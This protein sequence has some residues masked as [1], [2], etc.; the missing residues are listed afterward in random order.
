MQSVLL[1]I[2]FLSISAIAGEEWS[3]W[4]DGKSFRDGFIKKNGQIRF[5][6]DSVPWTLVF[7]DRRNAK[8][9]R[10]NLKTF[11]AVPE[12][13][14]RMTCRQDFEFDMSEGQ[15]KRLLEGGFILR[16]GVRSK[17]TS[18]W[19]DGKKKDLYTHCDTSTK[20]ILI[21]TDLVWDQGLLY[22]DCK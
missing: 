16:P 1:A 4:K 13:G 9:I 12:L 19:L 11:K 3:S 17:I 20:E 8:I 5:Q 10:Y 6:E 21:A 14:D 2:C 18:C 22:L 7:Y 15:E